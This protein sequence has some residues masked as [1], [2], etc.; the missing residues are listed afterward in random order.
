MGG[1]TT[2][3]ARVYFVVD[4]NGLY[5]AFLNYGQAFSSA[6]NLRAVIV[7]LPVYVD[8]RELVKKEE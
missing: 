7:A 8:L 2:A 3:T 1:K 5:G 6:A 4:N